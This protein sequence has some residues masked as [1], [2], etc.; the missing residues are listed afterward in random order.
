MPRL[1]L[2][3]LSSPAETIGLAIVARDKLPQPG[4][5]GQD[6]LDLRLYALALAE[7][8]GDR[9]GIERPGGVEQNLGLR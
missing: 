2:F 1:I 8:G 6:R 5:G 4:H 7:Q 9:A 3:G